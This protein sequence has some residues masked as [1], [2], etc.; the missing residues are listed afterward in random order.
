MAGLSANTSFYNVT[1]SAA[2]MAGRFGLAIPALAFCGHIARQGRRV[3]TAGTLPSDT[4]LFGVVALGSA[5]I[6]VALNFLP[7]IVLGPIIEHLL[8]RSSMTSF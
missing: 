5:L 4:P 7:A 3:T 2:M 1:T 8:M 6:V